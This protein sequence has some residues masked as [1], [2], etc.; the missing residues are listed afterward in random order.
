MP[1]QDLRVFFSLAGQIP[2]ADA[3]KLK[4]VAPN[5]LEKNPKTEGLTGTEKV[6]AG[7]AVISGSVISGDRTT[8]GSEVYATSPIPVASINLHQL[9]PPPRDFVGREAEIAQILNAVREKKISLIGLQ[10]RGGVGKTAVALLV[11]ERLREQYPDAQ[12]YFDLRGASEPVSATG[13]MGYVIRTY[14]P[15]AKLPESD[16]DIRGLYLTVLHNQRALLVMDNVV[17]AEQVQA[18][19][20]PPS[21]LIT[22]TSRQHLELEKMKVVPLDTLAQAEASALLIRIAPRLQ[23]DQAEKIIEVTGSLPL[24]LRLAGSMLVERADLSPEAYIERLQH[25]QNELQALDASLA[26]S[27]E[28]LLAPQQ[29]LICQLAVFPAD[30][31]ARGAAA[32]WN[33]PVE[34]ASEGLAEFARYSLLNVT[35][36]NNRYHLDIDVRRFVGARLEPRDR[37]EVALRHATQYEVVLREANTLYLQGGETTG[38]G[39]A[40]FDVER[41]NILAG[42]EWAEA[43][44]SA[45]PQ[46]AQLVARY[47][48]AGVDCIGLRLTIPERLQWFESALAVVQ[49]LND[50]A[51][52]ASA[53]GN[54]AIAYAENG[55]YQRAIDYHERA[56]G[57]ARIAGDR[58]SEAAILG[59]L[60]LAYMAIG[61]FTEALTLSH[62]H[63]AIA[64]ELGD[65]LGQS[66]AYSNLGNACAAIGQLEKAQEYYGHQQALSSEI[67]D[68]RGEGAA[69]TNIGNLELNKTNWEMALKNYQAALQIFHDLGDASNEATLLGNLGNVSYLKGDLPRAIEFYGQALQLARQ[70]VS[71]PDEANA[72]W[73]I[74]LAYKDLGEND[75]AVESAKAALEILEQSDDPNIE[76]LRQQLAEWE[77]GVPI[78]EGGSD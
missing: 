43:N 51:A 76:D 62:Q 6:T 27:F 49:Q 61:N 69:L 30:F 9:P 39:L 34:Q 22:R 28:Q 12:L 64:K 71:R 59:N 68:R 77:K 23:P 52:I 60:S 15:E 70:A 55:D 50:Q 31:D 65:K 67:G 5:P 47:V 40:L 78:K 7:E 37:A 74:G 10:G 18:L 56:L 75:K 20:P 25:S 19:I 38:R 26:L 36:P 24:A 44:F 17:D 16:A 21:C 14:R 46:V 48:T 41:V 73:N 4:E 58:F 54:L 63:L 33:L 32:I 11:A 57:F 53:V 13:A 8:G 35:S 2:V 29:R 1:V 45:S 66:K 72:L 42:K 3:E